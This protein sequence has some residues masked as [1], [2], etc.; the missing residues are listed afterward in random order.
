MKRILVPCDFSMPAQEAFK[1]AVAIARQSKGEVHVLYVLDVPYLKDNPI[2][3]HGNALNLEFIQNIEMK[4]KEQF[5][6]MKKLLAPPGLTVTF[7]TDINPLALSVETYI[8]EEHIDLVI[9]GAHTSTSSIWGMNSAKIVRYSQVPVITIRENPHKR[10]ENIIIP[11]SPIEYNKSLEGEL[12]KLQ[13]FFDARIHFL[14]VNTPL[15]FKTD[16][17]S[18]REM[19]HYA[20]ASKFEN[21]TLNTRSDLNIESGIFRFSKE[22]NADMIAIGTHAWKGLIHNLTINIAEKVVTHASLPIW[23]YD[24]NEKK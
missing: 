10:I 20:Q 17:E 8:N 6:A 4:G 23:T 7:K 9:M 24:M 19:K 3:S 5:D 18:E 12:K 14:W 11:I 22:K 16:A 1:F 15:F 2:M 13:A 21:Y